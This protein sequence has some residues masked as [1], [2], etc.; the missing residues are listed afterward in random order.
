MQK[1]ILSK[2]YFKYLS[3]YLEEG[4]RILVLKFSD[5]DVSELEFNCDFLSDKFLLE[6]KALDAKKTSEIDNIFLGNEVRQGSFDYILLDCSNLKN[7]DIDL[8]ILYKKIAEIIDFS[9]DNNVDFIV[10]GS[11]KDSILYAVLKD[12]S[13]LINK[14][15]KDVKWL[16]LGSAVLQN[17]SWILPNFVNR[18][19]SKYF[20][21]TVFEKGEAG[22][23]KS[24]AFTRKFLGLFKKKCADVAMNNFKSENNNLK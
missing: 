2:R 6:C 8:E 4:K 18:L 9:C 5:N 3:Q 11:C 16:F 21:F 13:K 7:S 23:V 17:L 24:E 14:R 12:Y 20:V 1:N 19:L 10:S 22:L 15:S